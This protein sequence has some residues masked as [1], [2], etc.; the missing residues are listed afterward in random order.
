MPTLFLT[1]SSGALAA[2][3][4]DRY[5][6]AGWSVAGFGRVANDFSHERF[7]FFES[8]AMNEASVESAFG[9]ATRAL[10]APRAL[11][12]TVGG[13]RPWRTV[14]ETSFEDFRF[15]VDL[16]LTTFFVTAKHAMKLMEGRGSIV[17]IGALP[18]LEPVAKRG[19]YAASKAGVV[20]LTRVLAEE[21]KD[22]GINANAI[23]PVVI[24]TKANEE[25]G[26]ADEI[27]KWTTPEDIAG[28]CFYLTSDDGA[29]VNGSTIRIPNGL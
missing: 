6:D 1:G 2:A 20:T 17:S 22:R 26:S 4:R 14:E 8:D 7:S 12:A 29:A 13:V 18:A 11:I 16:N 28:L 9:K 27:P 25:W 10:G 5:L 15:L 23:V 24:H 21:G 3:I 19:A